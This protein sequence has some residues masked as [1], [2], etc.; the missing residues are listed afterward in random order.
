[1]GI[2]ALSALSLLA[3]FEP[4]YD[5]WAWLVWGREIP[6]L[7]LDTTAGPSWK[8]LPVM[9]TTLLSPAG[10]AAPALWLFVVRAA[11]LGALAVGWKLAGR[12]VAPGAERS[13]ART[14]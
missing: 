3:Q 1:M 9:I 7:A 2:C 6:D 12:L 11:W 8:P 14:A 10:A 13:W 4:L 5:A